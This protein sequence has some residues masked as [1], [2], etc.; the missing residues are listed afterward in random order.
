MRAERSW[1]RWVGLANSAERG[2]PRIVRP[3]RR[4][5]RVRGGLL[6]VGGWGVGS[7]APGAGG[8]GVGCGRAACG[9]GGCR[10]AA[11]EGADCGSDG[12]GST[13]RDSSGAW[14]SRAGESRGP[15]RRAEGA[16]CWSSAHGNTAHGGARRTGGA[17]R[18]GG[19]TA[20]DS[21]GAWAGA[22]SGGR[23]LLEQRAREHGARGEHG[24]WGL[25]RVRVAWT[26]VARREGRACELDR[27]PPPHA[28]S[29]DTRARPL[30]PRRIPP[31]PGLAIRTGL[32]ALH[33][34]PPTH[35]GPADD[36]RTPHRRPERLPN[37]R[38]AVRLL[39]APRPPPTI[40]NLFGSM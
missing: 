4:R 40:R 1:A 26:G 36:S 14:E 12:L 11:R 22:T 30:P 18:V 19:S 20:R 33:P 29:P 35:T 37:P 5:H 16:S 27:P 38:S 39:F 8:P 9:R 21:S 10:R 2:Q 7:S 24:A 31:P 6:W 17:R 3:Q 25:R 28:R 15:A 13:A 34:A 32:I 23:E